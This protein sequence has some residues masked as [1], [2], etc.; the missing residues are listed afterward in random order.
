MSGKQCLEL[1]QNLIASEIEL[2]QELQSNLLTAGYVSQLIAVY[3]NEEI[4][5]PCSAVNYLLNHEGAFK[6]LVHADTNLAVLLL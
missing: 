5:D 1:A 6:Q 2:P 3:L 4:A